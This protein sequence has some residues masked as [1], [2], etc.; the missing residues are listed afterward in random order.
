[1]KRVS[2]CGGIA[3]AI[4]LGGLIRASGQR[5]APPASA[6]AS[7]VYIEELTWVEVRDKI[8]AGKTTVI[9]PTG[10]VEQSGP[11]MVLGKENF[12]MVYC[13]GEIAKRLGTALVAPNLAYVP[14]GGIDPPSGHMRFTGSITLPNEQFV[15]VLV[16]AGRSFKVNGFTDVALLGNSGGNMAGLKAAAEQLNKEWAG[17]GVR[18]HYINDYYESAA[19]AQGGKP[20]DSPFDHW[21]LAQGEKPDDIGNHAGI[22]DTSTLMAVEAQAPHVSRG[23]LVRWDR[24]APAADGSGVSGNPTHA[25]VAYGKKGLEMKIEAA[26]KQINTLTAKK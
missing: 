19:A 22:R 7:S 23:T 3:L 10:G 16:W 13:A 8:K 18:A 26:V 11:H 1:V 21:L 12:A 20:Y 24:I 5:A 9:M 14:E 25:S 6:P 4:V 2:V 17:T 15:Q